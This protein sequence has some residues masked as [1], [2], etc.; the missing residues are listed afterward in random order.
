MIFDNVTPCSLAGKIWPLEGAWCLK[1]QS[2]KNYCPSLDTEKNVNPKSRHL[3]TRLYGATY[4]KTLYDRVLLKKLTIRQLVKK[5]CAFYHARSFIKA[6]TVVHHPSISRA[7]SIQPTAHRTSCWRSIL[8]LFSNL[9]LGLPSGVF[10]SGLPNKRFLVTKI[11]VF[12]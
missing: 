7:G 6:F 4:E 9:R 2:G 1:F 10:L 12:F 8:I 3:S 5:L 11:N